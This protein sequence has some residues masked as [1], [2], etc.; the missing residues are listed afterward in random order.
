[1]V[2]YIHAATGAFVSLIVFSIA[3]IYI[4][5]VGPS[6]EVQNILTVSTFLFAII[7]GFFIARLGSRYN[8]VRKSIAEEDAL[9]LSVYQLSKAYG[10]KFTSKIRDLVD[11][12]YVLAYDKTIG[13][14]YK[15]NAP[16]FLNIWDNII[17]IGPKKNQQVYEQLLGNMTALEKSRNTSS[18]T[19][20]ERLHGGQ[21]FL[22][23]ILSGIVLFSIFYLK[24]PTLYS[25]IIAV[26]LSTALVLVLLILRDLENFMLGGESLLEESGQEVL[27][28]IGKKRYYNKWNLKAGVNKPPKD[29][30]EYR[31]GYHKPG[32]TKL[33][34]KLVKR[35]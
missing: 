19:Q 7:A 5:G 9:F 11:R 4:P 29:L 21:W 8:E 6:A 16:T 15:E 25:Q 31:E 33:D 12:Y 10:E 26:L 17:K 35:K 24:T 30:K 32:S 20:T 2:K 13:S 27:E 18:G 34:I 23:L 1:M 14:V 28:F 22:L 3:V